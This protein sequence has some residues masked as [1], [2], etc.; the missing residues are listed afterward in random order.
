MHSAVRSGL[1]LAVGLVAAV[2]LGAQEADWTEV[3][4]RRQADGVRAVEVDVEYV[5]GELRI[6]PA[7]D[8]LLY[9]SRLRYDAARMRP[10][11]SWT[12]D[13]DV[14][15]LEIGFEGLG[16]DGDI[17][18]D[19]DEHEHGYLE[20]GLS[21]EIPTQLSLRVG[22]ALSEVELGGIPLTGLVYETGASET[23]LRI[24]S[25]NPVPM[26]KLE[27]RAGAA[28][29]SASGLG[30][31]RFEEL[32]FRGGVGEVTLDFTGQWSSDASAN[33]EIG[34]GSIELVVPQG[35][36]VRIVKS[37]F[38][39]DLDAPGFERVDGAWQSPNWDTAPHRLQ[40]R[41]RAAL[42]SIEVRRI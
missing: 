5:A 30:N 10:E 22:A 15:R 4:A 34:L 26:E 40:I 23:N 18:L 2:P 39:A 37:G 42:G 16:R 41:L 35:L 13:G 25:P 6:A 38:L 31:A 9:D 7:D 21:Q 11:R 17:D 20:L 32:D 29:F 3:R 28:S 14:G 36:G 8:G 24:G 33:L 1:L 19:V 12:V 27:L